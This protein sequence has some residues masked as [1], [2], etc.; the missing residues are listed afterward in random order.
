[1]DDPAIGCIEAL[2]GAL[3]SRI[4][5]PVRDLEGPFLMHIEDVFTVAGQGTV[6]TGRVARGVLPAGEAVEIVGL[7]DDERKPRKVVVRS[8]EA[9]HRAQV[10]ARAGENVGLLLRGVKRDEVARGQVIAAPGSVLAHRAGAAE[11]FV[12]AAEE[13]GRRTPFTTGY[14]PQFFFGT[15][16]VTGAL[17]VADDALVRP[18]DRASVEFELLKPVGVEPG[19]RFAMREG[20]RTIGAGVVTRVDD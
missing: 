13:G 3:D 14:R 20:S 1:M 8:I 4:A 2:V 7:V 11:I 15:T 17:R 6:V 19:M 16:D 10:E 12:L 18:G 5:D 9:F